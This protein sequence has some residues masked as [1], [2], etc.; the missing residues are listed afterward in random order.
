MYNRMIFCHKNIWSYD[1]IINFSMISWSWFLRFD[2][3]WP[4][5]PFFHK[6]IWSCD[7]MINFSMIPWSWFWDL[8][9]QDHTSRDPIVIISDIWWSHDYDPGKIVILNYFDHQIPW[10][11]DYDPANSMILRIFDFWLWALNCENVRENCFL[12]LFFFEF[13]FNILLLF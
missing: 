10:S 13:F 3:P 7:L 9:S 6:N 4:K 5:N 8:M 12:Y 2:D 1:L 11:H